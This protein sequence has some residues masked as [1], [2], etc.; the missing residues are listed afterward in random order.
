M[1][2]TSIDNKKIKDIKKL[3]AKK[4][5]DET[6]SFL[7]EGEHLVLEAYKKNI[8]KELILEENTKLDI[9]VPTS[10]VSY[11]VLKYIS[12]LDTPQKIMAICNKKE[13]LNK[14][15]KK[16]LIL[17]NIQ[18]PGNLGTIIRSAVAFNI[19]T[20]VLSDDTVDLYNS[21]VIRASQG[22]LF[23]INII[24]KDLYK[25][26]LS[27]KDNDYNIIGTNVINGKEVNNIE[28]HDKIAI[29]MGNEGNG[30]KNDICSLCDDFI[31][32][33]MNNNCESLNVAVATSI[34]LYEL[35]K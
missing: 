33:D 35:N 21:K 10:Y 27:L 5:R 22:M 20:I 25:F 11:N 15:G 30:I 24:R 16:I 31:Y 23:H 14:L 28:K 18:D 34:I 17:E 8:I 3:N 6:N 2:Y 1:I 32:I 9:N 12:E 7:V 13:E 26:I 29:I 4:Y 19:D